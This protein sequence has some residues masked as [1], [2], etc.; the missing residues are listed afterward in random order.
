MRDPS[1]FVVRLKRNNG[2]IVEPVAPAEPAQA[3]IK[4]DTTSADL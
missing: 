2:A 3:A 4:T 1:K